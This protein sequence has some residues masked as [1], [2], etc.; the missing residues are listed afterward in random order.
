M[1]LPDETVRLK[2][3]TTTHDTVRLKADTTTHD[4]VRLKADTTTRVDQRDSGTMP[5]TNA[6]TSMTSEVIVD[7]LSVNRWFFA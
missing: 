6:T 1:T 2:A 3:D 4:T 5:M 7:H